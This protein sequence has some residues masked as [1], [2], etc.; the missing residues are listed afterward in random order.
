MAARIPQDVDLED[1]L[2]FG[3]SPIRFGY[4]VAGVIVAV[5]LWSAPWP[6]PLHALVALPIA[7]AL[8]L[9]FGS[10][11]GHR[12]DGLIA[13]AAQHMVRNYRIELAKDFRALLHVAK[14]APDAKARA[15][16]ITVMAVKPGAGATT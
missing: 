3:L 5:L 11:R 8:A 13:D 7:S 15:R 16:V 9:S 14:Q 10:W 4:L 6:L 12:V 1:K 2:I